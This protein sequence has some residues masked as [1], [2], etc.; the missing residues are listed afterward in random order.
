MWTISDF[1]GLGALSGWNTYTGLA[2]PSCNLDFTPCRLS[3]SKKWC[4]MGHRRFLDQ[5][6]K[7]RLNKVRFDGQQEM[8]NPP[9]TL[10]G[11]QILAQ[12]EEMEEK[13]RMEKER[14][15]NDKN[16]SMK[17][18][19]KEKLG[20]R[21]C[22]GQ[23]TQSDTQQWKKKSIFFELPYWKDNLLRHN[24]DMMHIEKNVCDNIIFTLLN[25]S[26][27]SKDHVNARKDLEDMCIRPDLWPNDN[28]RISPAVF[29]LTGKGKRGFLTTLKNIRVPDGYSSNISRCIDLENLKL[30]GMLKS[31]DCHILMEQLLPLAIRTTLPNEVSA[32]LIELCSFFR[33]L[34]GKVLKVEDLEK[35]QNQIVLTLC[36]M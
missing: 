28:G 34:C 24:L 7:F 23:S 11:H 33:Q 20:K 36:H 27:K 12:I 16:E 21:T 6:H 4:F 5:R 13:K 15:G 1:P 30:N 9:K 18:K 35:L 3:K 26:K 2:C 22:G 8:R 10:S 31:H 32:V 25:D 17:R 29:T 14:E 19:R